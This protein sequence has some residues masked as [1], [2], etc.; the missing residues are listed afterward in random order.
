MLLIPKTGSWCFKVGVAPSSTVLSNCG[1]T[2]RIFG[3]NSILR[4]GGEALLPSATAGDLGSPHRHLPK[5]AGCS[6]LC[7]A[8]SPHLPQVTLTPLGNESPRGEG[9]SK[10]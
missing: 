9:G 10:G 4:E 6:P 8:C 1:E 5:P 3:A 2:R 7:S